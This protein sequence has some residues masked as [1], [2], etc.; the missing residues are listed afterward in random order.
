[1]CL[2]FVF[3]SFS[4]LNKNLMLISPRIQLQHQGQE[5]VLYRKWQLQSSPTYTCPNMELQIFDGHATTLSLSLV[6]PSVALFP[7]VELQTVMDRQVWC[8]VNVGYRNFR[9][10]CS[11]YIGSIVMYQIISNILFE[12][13]YYLFGIGYVFFCFSKNEMCQ[14]L[15]WTE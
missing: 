11:R 10:V 3:A 15:N 13:I 2:V 12:R 6:Q 8:F 9:V 5:H 7:L 14:H 4:F 1:M